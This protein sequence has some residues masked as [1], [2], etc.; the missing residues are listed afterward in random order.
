MLST[1]PVK[2]LLLYAVALGL[3]PIIFMMI[4]L[5]SLSS[6][7]N[8][9]EE[10]IDAIKTLADA[11]KKRQSINIATI[12]HYREADH[13]Y[14]DKHLETLNFLEPEVEALQKIVGHKNFPGDPIIKKR[15]EFL[16]GALNSAIFNEGTVQSFPFYQETVETLA[17]PIE[18]NVQ[19][20]KNILAMTEGVEIPP[21]IP[22]T[23]RPQLIMLDFKMDRKKHQ[24]GNEVFLLNMK[25]L[26]REFL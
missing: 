21:F 12:N 20:I 6:E 26:K 8:T 3:L 22:L 5:S 2:R 10:R 9:V 1:I 15:L 17:H 25:L 13:F 14:I 7:A 4:R 18:V 23:S 16:T 24:D 11:Y 19:D